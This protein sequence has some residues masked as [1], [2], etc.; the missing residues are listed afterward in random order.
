MNFPEDIRP[1]IPTKYGL[2]FA[3][4]RSTAVVSGVSQTR[5]GRFCGL[6]AG[7]L[8]YE[9]YLDSDVQTLWDF[10]VARAGAFGAFTF[11]D[12][13][14]IDNSPVGIKWPKLY[15]ATTN[16]SATAFDLPMKNSSGYTVGPVGADP[17]YGLFR[18]GTRL[19][20]GTNYTFSAGTGVDGC[21]KVTGLVAGAAGDILEW[22]ATGRAS[23]T[24]R[25]VRDD[26]TFDGF[27][28]AMVNTGLE[29]VEAP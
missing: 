27:V 25:F 26:L 6:Y 8:K 3:T 19:V 10:Y 5:R 13:G 18:A 12:F 7:A 24:V 22:R 1:T 4:L 28:A 29:V 15:V 14:G 20:S 9:N 11:T 2:T 21:D 16:G 23:F 17:G